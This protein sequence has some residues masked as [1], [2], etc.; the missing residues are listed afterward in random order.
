MTVG[1]KKSDAGGKHKS[2]DV[3]IV[4]SMSVGMSTLELG[5]AQRE[6]RDGSSVE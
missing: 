2:G 3:L 4:E 6:R 5:Y 1:E